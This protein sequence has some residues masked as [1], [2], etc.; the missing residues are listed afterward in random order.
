MIDQTNR[1]AS[2][3]LST[4]VRPAPIR[5]P[6]V[7]VRVVAINSAVRTADESPFTPFGHGIL[8]AGDSPTD[9]GGR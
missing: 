8:V 9:V 5:L 7:T 2:V 3:V 1:A 4:G 6:K